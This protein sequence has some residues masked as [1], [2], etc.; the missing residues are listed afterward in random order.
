[1]HISLP[2]SAVCVLV[3]FF[4]FGLEQVRRALEA[5]PGIAAV[6]AP[7]STTSPA[8]KFCYTHPKKEEIKNLMRKRAA[9]AAEKA[10]ENPSG[11][12]RTEGMTAVDKS[13]GSGRITRALVRRAD[14]EGEGGGRS[15]SAGKGGRDLNE[16]KVETA[17]QEKYREMKSVPFEDR[18][19][20]KRSHIHGW[21]L[22][23][24]KE[25]RKHQMII[26]YMG[27]L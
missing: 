13:G 7:L 22:F 16:T 25:I 4:G 1:M 20:A 17:I 19:V 24:K 23:T 8:Y 5:S 3:K 14:D 18:L 9:L 11:S 27:E 21:G 2:V 15:A 26:E 10:L 12:A 6:A